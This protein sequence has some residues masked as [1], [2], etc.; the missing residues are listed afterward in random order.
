LNRTIL[1]S[2]N[3]KGNA[4]TADNEHLEANNTHLAIMLDHGEF[5]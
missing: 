5:N 2:T 4:R 1:S 3:F